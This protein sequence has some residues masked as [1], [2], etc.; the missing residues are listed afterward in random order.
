LCGGRVYLG[1]KND[2]PP[3]GWHSV[4]SHVLFSYFRNRLLP[5]S[6][7]CIFQPP[8]RRSSITIEKKTF[9]APRIIGATLPDG[10]LFQYNV[11]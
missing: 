1:G 3:P 4:A 11:S 9:A 2:G 8:P 7:D 10:D 6:G 5:K